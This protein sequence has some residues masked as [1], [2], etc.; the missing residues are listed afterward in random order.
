M[1]DFDGFHKATFDQVLNTE[2]LALV[3]TDIYSYTNFRASWAVD[4]ENKEDL[5]V[6]FF[7]PEEGSPEKLWFNLG[8]TLK[9][10]ASETFMNAKNIRVAYTDE[11][12]SWWVRIH[13]AAHPLF[14]T[15]DLVNKY[16][17]RVDTMCDA[18][19]STLLA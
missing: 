4:G 13:K 2:E 12:K 10:A 9:F 1:G 16:V 17:D 3:F 5:I 11:M 6:H 15:S 8:D 18:I 14:S 19:K 7:L